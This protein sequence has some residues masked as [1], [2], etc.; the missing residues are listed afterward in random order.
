[1]YRPVLLAISARCF[2]RAQKAL[3]IRP[4]RRPDQPR[5]KLG[6]RVRPGLF[7]LGVVAPLVAV[8]E[9]LASKGPLLGARKGKLLERERAVKTA[10]AADEDPFVVPDTMRVMYLLAS[11]RGGLRG[12]NHDFR[13][14]VHGIENFLKS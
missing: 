3:L 12:T 6:S 2:K 13:L 7:G 10:L 9:G 14:Q 1:M 11:N 8:Q 4:E 5:G